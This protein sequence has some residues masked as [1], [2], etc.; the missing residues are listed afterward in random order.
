MNDDSR[1]QAESETAKSSQEVEI[2]THTAQL[3]LREIPLNVIRYWPEGMPGRLE[4]VWKDL[5]G[6]IPN[7][8]L[9]DLQ[10]TLAEFGFVMKVYEPTNPNPTPAPVDTNQADL[11][12]KALRR[13]WELGQ[14][15]WQQADS[16]SL[17]QQAKS[18]QTR[19]AFN[20]LIE[21]TC[22]AL[23]GKDQP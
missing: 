23:T 11:V 7:Y 17:K 22:D 8:K 12:R 10:R 3:G 4:A 13:A 2:A 18:D 5:L 21:E 1:A 19:E 15:Y 6:F 20:A 9:Y 14:T 16:E